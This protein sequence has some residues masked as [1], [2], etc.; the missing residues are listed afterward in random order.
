MINGLWEDYIVYLEDD[1][2]FAHWKLYRNKK[3]LVVLDHKDYFKGILTISDF[4]KTY[5]NDSYR[6]VEEI[7]NSTCK[8]LVDDGM[9]LEHARSLFVDYHSINHI[10]VIDENGMLTDI[11]SREQ[12]FWKKYYNDEKLP[13]MH[14]AYC[15]YMAALEAKTLGYKKISIIE[16]GVAGGQGLMNCEFHAKAVSRLMNIDIEIY[17]FDRGIG[18]PTENKEYKDMVHLFHG[19]DYKMDQDKLQRKIA[20]SQL[21]IGEIAETTQNFFEKYNPATIGC[22]LVD[23]DYYSSTLPILDFLKMEDTRFLPRIYTYW[24]D[25]SPEY[26]FQGEALA[27]RE[28]NSKN[29]LIKIS[30]EEEFYQNYRQKIKICHKFTHPKYNDAS[31]V[32]VGIGSLQQDAP[33]FYHDLPLNARQI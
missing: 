11:I 30:P 22:V 25:I 15:I 26:E 4:N 17:G 29:E 2:Y 12:A 13:R 9:A 31:D 1:I 21:V 8:Y 6:K 3:I 16:F 18:L 32:Y 10:P 27:I 7:Y 24:D 28:F 14:Y 19:G 20:M 33:F 5:F 23:V